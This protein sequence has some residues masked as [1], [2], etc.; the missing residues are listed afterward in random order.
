MKMNSWRKHVFRFLKLFI[1]FSKK[2]SRIILIAFPGFNFSYRWMYDLLSCC[3]CIVAYYISTLSM[4][5][6]FVLDFHITLYIVD[7]CCIF[8]LI[9]VM[10][11]FF[12]YSGKRLYDNFLII[13]SK[14]WSRLILLMWAIYEFYYG[15]VWWIW[16]LVVT[17]SIFVKEFVMGRRL[18][19]FYWRGEVTVRPVHYW[20]YVFWCL[21][22]VYIQAFS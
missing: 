7:M 14:W 1:N 12:T 22:L 21:R 5:I 6:N 9:I 4:F 16:C 15:L 3:L 8:I 17:T 18:N 13:I 10:S 11:L 20:I 2:F 19:Y